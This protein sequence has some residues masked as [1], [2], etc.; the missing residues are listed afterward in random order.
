MTLWAVGE[1]RSCRSLWQ[2]ALTILWFVVLLLSAIGLFVG[3]LSIL[4]EGS[5]LPLDFAAAVLCVLLAVFSLKE[6]GTAF[7]VSV[8]LVV[9][10]CALAVW[11]LFVLRDYGYWPCVGLAGVGMIYVVSKLFEHRDITRK[12]IAVVTT[13]TLI[14][15]AGVIFMSQWRTGRVENLKRLVAQLEV[16][17]PVDGDFSCLLDQVADASIVFL[18]ESTH[19]TI[20]IKKT[21]MDLGVFLAEHANARVMG[22][23]SFYGWH[24][25]MEAESMGSTETSG[26]VRPEILNYNKTVSDDRRLLLTALDIEHSIHHSKRYTIRYLQHLAARSSSSQGREKIARF[27]P[28]LRS[29][30]PREEVHAYLNTLEDLFTGY[31]QTF[32]GVDWEEV[33]FSLE[34]MRASIDYQMLYPR[35]RSFVRNRNGIADIQEIRGKYFR[36]TIE[37]ALAKAENRNGKLVCYVGA[38]H[39]LKAPPELNDASLGYQSEADYF[40]RIDPHLKGQV[41]SILLHALLF[42]DKAFRETFD[43]DD[44]AYQVMGDSDLLYIPLAPLAAGSANLAWSKY[45]TEDGPKYDGVLFFKNVSRANRGL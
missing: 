19:F 23:E 16:G 13:S 29:L 22:C 18:G 2:L 15:V 9:L 26:H 28:E 12:T 4:P 20:E 10:A 17:R 8:F 38:A 1:R 11:G 44:V 21:A 31:K 3:W 5:L 33:S 6:S 34:L 41:A 24:P 32:D 14:G 36:K 7:L 45:F 37:R 42:K 30:K 40:N 43:L 35:K 39:A 27:I 25:F